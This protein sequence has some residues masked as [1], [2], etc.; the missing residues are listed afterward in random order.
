MRLEVGMQKSAR[1]IAAQLQRGLDTYNQTSEFV[2]LITANYVG[3]YRWACYFLAIARNPFVLDLQHAA[4][5]PS[6][7]TTLGTIAQIT[8]GTLPKLVTE[9]EVT[10]DTTREQAACLVKR[11]KLASK[12]K[13]E[14]VRRAKRGL[15]A[16]PTPLTG[17]AAKAEKARKAEERSRRLAAIAEIPEDELA[18]LGPIAANENDLALYVRLTLETKA[19]V[20]AAVQAG[21]VNRI[22]GALEFAECIGEGRSL[23]ARDGSAVS[24]R[25]TPAMVRLPDILSPVLSLMGQLHTA[26]RKARADIDL[27]PQQ[28]TVDPVTFGRVPELLSQ[29]RLET[30]EDWR[31]ALSLQV[32]AVECEACNGAGCVSCA[33]RGWLDIGTS[34]KRQADAQRT[35]ELRGLEA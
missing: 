20:I 25:I 29:V 17:D 23:T 3:G 4:N 12:A 8:D 13:A 11:W 26:L 5:L 28:A 32:P 2:A 7:V 16:K 33:Q 21:H 1:L 22:K 6:D 31:R 30:L 18:D 19:R 14:A 10:R 35:R 24:R 9:G 27:M 15:P 34:K